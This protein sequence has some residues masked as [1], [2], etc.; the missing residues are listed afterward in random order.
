MT[1]PSVPSNPNH[2]QARLIDL[3]LLVL[4]NLMF[5]AQYPA[6]KTSV[7]SMGP[8]FLSLMTFVLGAVCLAPFFIVESRAHPRQPRALT[9][10]RG[11]NL[12]PFL[13]AT[14]LGFIPASVVLAWGIERSLA[15]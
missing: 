13:M 8:V 2:R 3:G 7:T 5:G 9:L 6:T 10:F 15:T 14:A 4:C 11:R 12:F 1:E